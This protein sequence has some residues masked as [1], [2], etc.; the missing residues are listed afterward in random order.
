MPLQ[1]H[2]DKTTLNPLLHPADYALLSVTAA[3]SD[4]TPINLSEA[5]VS[6]SVQ[7][8]ATSGNVEVARLDGNHLIGLEGGIVK[9]TAS[10]VIESIAQ[11]ASLNIVV[12]PF[13]REYHQTLT[14]KLYMGQKKHADDI[15]YHPLHTFESAL[16]LIQKVDA[17][18]LGIPKILY[19][20]GWQLNGHDWYYPDWSPG[21]YPRTRPRCSDLPIA[22]RFRD[23]A[24]GHQ[25]GATR[26]FQT[27]GG[28]DHQPGKLSGNGI[29]HT[30]QSRSAA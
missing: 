15:S 8:L 26:L 13:H 23:R 3:H 16:D 22:R 10:A 20:V 25:P 4:G 11:Q 24:D 18:T 21:L 9:V 30:G 19:L 28:E 14:M 1:L 27:F 12:R 17:V 2:A 6:Y 5:E 7:T 29:S